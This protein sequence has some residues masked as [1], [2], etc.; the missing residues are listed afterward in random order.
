M[1]T[2][3]GLVCSFPVGRLLWESNLL[4]AGSSASV[5]LEQGELSVMT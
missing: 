5:E 4:L 2:L 3:A 1:F